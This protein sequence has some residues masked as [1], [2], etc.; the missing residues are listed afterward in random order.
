MKKVLISA[1]ALLCLALTGCDS[2]SDTPQTASTATP[3]SPSSSSQPQQRDSKI[4]TINNNWS[5]SIIVSGKYDD[6]MVDVRISAGDSDSLMLDSDSVLTVNYGFGVMS[7]HCPSTDY[8][9]NF[10][11]P[12]SFAPS[13]EG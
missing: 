4:V 9:F 10:S 2:D 12:Y 3:S 13:G 6:V 11:G 1:G 5:N 7:Y 8:T